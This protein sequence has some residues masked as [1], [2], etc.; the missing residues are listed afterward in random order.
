LDFRLAG[1]PFDITLCDLSKVGVLAE[2]LGRLTDVLIAGLNSSDKTIR[3]FILLAHWEAQS[4]WQENYTDLYDFC[5]L[6]YLKCREAAPSSETMKKTVKELKL[7]CYEMMKALSKDNVVGEARDGE[8]GDPDLQEVKPGSDYGEAIVR[9]RFT[10][11][12]YQYSHGLSIFFPWSEPVAN[13]MWDEQYERYQLNKD[14]K[15]KGEQRAS[16]KDFLKK[17]FDTTLRPTRGAE[18]EAMARRPPRRS[19]DERRLEELEDY[20]ASADSG[21]VAPRGGIETLAVKAGIDSSLSGTPV[22]P[23]GGSSLNGTPVKPGGGSP[24]GGC[25]FPS[26]KNYPR[27]SR[28]PV[29]PNA[30]PTLKAIEEAEAG[31]A[32]VE[33]D[34][35]A[36]SKSSDTKS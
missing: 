7:A 21:L 2:P 32:G 16:W 6:L 36:E 12:A 19:R 22:K 23:G 27:T 14:M 8:T 33:E 24:L 5:L 9:S 26:I 29:M 1:Y 20:F 11:A 18:D 4:Y 28:A 30:R 35:P 34:V 31:E 10:G 13:R 3:H 25:D 15:G 17:Y